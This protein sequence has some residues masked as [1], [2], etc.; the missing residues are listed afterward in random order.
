M[1]R[2]I[3]TLLFCLGAQMLIFGQTVKVDSN[4]Q[5]GYEQIESEVVFIH[6]NASLVLVGDYLYY[7]VYVLNRE[8]FKK[9]AVSKIAYVTLIGDNGAEIFKHKINLNQARGQ[10]DFFIPV[11]VPSGNYKLIGYTQWMTNWSEQSFFSSDVT[12][13]NPYTNNQKVFRVEGE[14]N[15]DVTKELDT[16]LNPNIANISSSNSKDICPYVI[17]DKEI[18]SKREKI[19]LSLK[20][21]MGSSCYGDFSI[22][23]RRLNKVKFSPKV[24]TQDLKKRFTQNET[25]V[26][27]SKEAVLPE[28]RGDLVSGRLISKD[29]HVPIEGRK[30]LFSIPGPEYQ[31][32]VLTTDKNGFFNFSLDKNYTGDKAFFEILSD[33]PSDFRIVLDEEFTVDYQQFK[34][35]TFSLRPE[36]K[37]IIVQN[38]IYNQIENAY[39]KAKPDTLKIAEKTEPFYGKPEIIYI[40]DDYTRFKTIEE[41][42][43]EVV[44]N[45][46]VTKD[47]NDRPFLSVRSL[48]SSHLNTGYK[49]LVLVDGI[50]L[51][52]IEPLL[53]FDSRNVKSIKILR[54]KYFMGSQIFQGVVDFK[55]FDGDFHNFLNFPYL[56]DI[57]L[58][59]PIRLK[60]YFKQKYNNN[61][62]NSLKNIP[63]YRQQLL[64]IPHINIEAK[65]TVIDFFTSDVT[66]D[67]EISI[68][69]FSKEGKA[70]SIKQYFKVE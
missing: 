21:S 61:A 66:G 53:N 52:N 9:S 44:G 57:D 5:S 64:W 56:K 41:T 23:V 3:M 17:L 28:L 67:F 14:S 37:D 22:S 12:I 39:F 1:Q 19:I 33:N 40:L 51:Q 34:F 6:Y 69:G 24:S 36:M 68:E 25:V 49:A 15:S 35:D 38:S 46:W 70:T 18:A 31:F 48:Y 62:Q 42:L 55:T 32:K 4:L 65:D 59:K 60:N 2:T 26:F 13:I 43:I 45:V 54:N 16:D 7:S 47:K 29:S 27:S 30:I 8:T 11:S 10:G 63:D 20:N 50:A 58:F